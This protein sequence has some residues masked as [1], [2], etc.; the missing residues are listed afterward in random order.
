MANEE[1]TLKASTWIVSVAIAAAIGAAIALSIKPEQPPPPPLLTLEKTGQLV[2]LKVNV[3]DIVEFTKERS[4]DIAWPLWNLTY[5]GTK[6]VLILRGD[7]LLVTDLRLATYDAV[8]QKAKTVSVTLKTPVTWQPR[9]NHDENGSKLYAISNV[10][11]E[12]ILPGDDNRKQAIDAAWRLAQARVNRAGLAPDAMRAA[13][14]NAEL[15]VKG[16]M[17]GLGWD[18]KIKWL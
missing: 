16:W 5:G 13:K 6:V 1:K 15:V 2:A 7:C 17:M 18:A 3:A 11:I 10:G 12:A 14:E 4:S 8:D 9:V